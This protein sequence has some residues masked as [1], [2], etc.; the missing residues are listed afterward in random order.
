M[1]KRKLWITVQTEEETTDDEILLSVV[2]Q[3]SVGAMEVKAEI[4]STGQ[5]MYSKN[6]HGK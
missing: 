3:L 2:N 6:Y 1:P 4:Y 5:R